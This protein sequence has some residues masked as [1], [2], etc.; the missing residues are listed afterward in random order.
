MVVSWG[1]LLPLG[2]LSARLLRH[3]PDNAL[4]FKINRVLQP[5][6]LLLAIVG[7][8]VALA[9]PFDVLGSGIYDASFAHGVMGTIVMGLGIFQPINAFVRPHKPSNPEEA[10]SPNRRKWEITHKSAGYIAVVVGFINCFI[11][12]ALVGKYSD[13]FFYAL[14]A[15]AATLVAFGA[16]ACWDKRRQRETE[17]TEAQG[18][19]EAKEDESPAESDNTDEADK[20][21]SKP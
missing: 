15:S 19:V 2:V 14:I 9:G 17:P 13:Q 16:G 4:W 1:F 5:M 10:P 7:W 21:D 12:M 20:I 18:L 6:G 11:G 3:L 8:I